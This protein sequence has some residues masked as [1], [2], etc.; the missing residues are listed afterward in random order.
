M[1]LA[2]VNDSIVKFCKYSTEKW[3]TKLQLK[4]NQE[5]MQSKPI[6]IKRGI[7]Q[8]DSSPPLLFCI[9]LIPLTH[10]LNRTRC[11]YWVHES[12]RKVSHLLY[13]DD[14]KLIGKNKEELRDEIRI[15]KTFSNDL[16]FGFGLL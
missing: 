3:N 4:T 1:K 10:E 11:R 5:L 13:M 14:L 9:A 8:G 2:G 7:F 6:K 16:K 12:E 15:A